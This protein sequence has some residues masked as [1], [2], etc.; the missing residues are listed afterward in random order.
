[1]DV[2]VGEFFGCVGRADRKQHARHVV[3]GHVGNQAVIVNCV[4]AVRIHGGQHG[5]RRGHASS[6]AQSLTKQQTGKCTEVV[7][8]VDAL[9]LFHDAHEVAG[10]IAIDAEGVPDALDDIDGGETANGH[11][12]VRSGIGVLRVDGDALAGAARVVGAGVFCGCRLVAGATALV[13]AG[14]FHLRREGKK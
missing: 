13:V 7:N 1:V 4:V 12:V 14:W 11:V 6:V 3:G 5:R 9:A 10:G 8:A 2:G